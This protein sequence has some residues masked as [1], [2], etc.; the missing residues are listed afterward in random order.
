MF[1]KNYKLF[2]CKLDTVDDCI[3]VALYSLKQKLNTS[4]TC[5]A[6]VAEQQKITLESPLQMIANNHKTNLTHL[7]KEE[8]VVF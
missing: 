4:L 6:Q 7:A 5:I 8:L 2:N 1:Q 3:S